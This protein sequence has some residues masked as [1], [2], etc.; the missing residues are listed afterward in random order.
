[1]FARIRLPRGRYLVGALA[2]FS[3]TCGQAL[4]AGCGD[5][6]QALR[7]AA[8]RGLIEEEATRSFYDNVGGRCAW[9]DSSADTLMDALKAAGDHGLDPA[10]FNV[11]A[12]GPN[13][14]PTERDVLLTDG[15]LKYAAVMTRGLGGR[16]ERSRNKDRAHSPK[17]ELPVSLAQ[18]LDRGD[19]QS[20]LEGL[21]PRTESYRRLMWAMQN[22]RAIEQ[23]GGF[24]VMP[25]NLAS[26]S[27]RKWR[28]Y[29]AL[30]Q[31]LVMEG[32]IGS[33]NGSNEYD[34]ELRNGVARFQDRNGLASTGFVNW[35]TL[36]R[37]NVSAG[38]RIAQIA[39]NLDRLRSQG[40]D[41]PATRVEVNIPAATAVLF[42]DGTPHLR[43]N[44][45]V[46]SPENETPELRSTIDSIVI[47][48][49]W[50]IPE[51]IIKKEILPAIKR[52]KNYLARN[53]MSWQGDLL[54]QEPGPHNALG[55]IKFDFPN[56]YSVYLHDTPSRRTFSNPERAESH[57]CV[58]LERPLDLAAEL[59]QGSERWDR[60]SIQEAIDRGKTRRVAV[61]EPMPV[62]IIY[63]TVFVGDDGAVNFRPDVYGH[64]TKLTLSLAQRAGRMRSE[65]AQW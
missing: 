30:R 3:L 64:D 32:D 1:M 27:K 63:Q 42:R 25:D 28:N 54:V 22:Y 13:S 15:A 52:K 46:G 4:A 37:L 2:A 9:G 53:R 44:A 31:R 56:R 58:R 20:W 41:P 61:S 23:S 6:G 51:S 39:V 60:A 5:V 38:E 43:M 33:D 49:T 19:V 48:P 26:K 35:K 18:A 45:V 11:N 24:P 12:V 50:T 62:V 59:L 57:G 16:E 34:D 55:R 47:N 10:L 14:D 29:A 36:A 17:D 65:G 7:Q 8:N 21:Q 40:E